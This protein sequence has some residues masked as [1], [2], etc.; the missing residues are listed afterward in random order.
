LLLSG[1]CSA[2]TMFYLTGCSHAAFFAQEAAAAN[3]AVS[4]A[5]N[6]RSEKASSPT[7]AVTVTIEGGLGEKQGGAE[8]LAQVLL[9]HLDLARKAARRWGSC[10]LHRQQVAEKTYLIFLCFHITVRPTAALIT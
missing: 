3:A 2:K 6:T 4:P 9:F 8:V 1:R 7:A 5:A 10:P